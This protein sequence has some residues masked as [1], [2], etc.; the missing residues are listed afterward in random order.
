MIVVEQD[1]RVASDVPGWFSAM[2]LYLRMI[3]S[4]PP[5]STI[6]EVG[7]FCG[8]S[9]IFL[10]ER[11]R[12]ADKGL[13]IVGV[14]NFMGSPEFEGK[15]FFNDQPWSAAPVGTLVRCCMESLSRRGVLDDVTLIVSDSA[16]AAGMFADESVHAVFIDADHSEE[17]C[18][19]DI[20]AWLPKVAPGG[21][22]AGDD[23]W[24]FPGVKA[25]VDK[26]VPG[27]VVDETCPWW[28]RQC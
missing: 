15:V 27:V 6:V 28:E 8:Q 13:R 2:E 23:Y 24:A 16:K 25:A 7:V 4:A 14:D 1:A 5:G 18:G 20:A 17:G 12:E 9:L 3:E 19:G 21:I 10:A 11:A 26:L 22:I